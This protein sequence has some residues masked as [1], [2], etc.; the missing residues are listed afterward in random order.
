MIKSM[1]ITICHCVKNE[2]PWTIIKCNFENIE[3]KGCNINTLLM[4]TVH[5]SLL[6]QEKESESVY[7]VLLIW[8]SVR[9]DA[10]FTENENKAVRDVS[11][12][13]DLFSSGIDFGKQF[14]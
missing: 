5:L 4:A 11:R 7:Q 2:S 10:L 13:F 14:F 6:R 8:T 1:A 9:K 3:V 12:F